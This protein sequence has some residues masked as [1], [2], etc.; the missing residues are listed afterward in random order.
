MN[1]ES[2]ELVLHRLHDD[3][4]RKQIVFEPKRI[5]TVVNDLLARRGYA[6]VQGAEQLAAAWRVAAGPALANAS[7]PGLI[8][9]GVLNVVVETSVAM[10]ELTM[11]RRAILERL[12]K[13]APE[14]KVVGLKFRVGVIR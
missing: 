9:K 10:Q 2:D 5:R 12:G 1:E 4:R 6:Q 11:R 7:K 8:R 14:L 13:E 3:V